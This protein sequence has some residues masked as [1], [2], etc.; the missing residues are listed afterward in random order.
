VPVRSLA[1][2]DAAEHF[3]WL[4][5]FFGADVPASSALTRELLGWQPSHPGLIEDLEA[6]RYFS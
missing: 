2:E 4:A 6:G 3:G 5:A 1:P